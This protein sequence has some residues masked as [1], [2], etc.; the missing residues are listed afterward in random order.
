LY[1]LSTHDVA[2]N[3]LHRV[4][5]GATASLLALTDAAANKTPS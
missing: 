2:S 1:V 4:G 3:I 5:V